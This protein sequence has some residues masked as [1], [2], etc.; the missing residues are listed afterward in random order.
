MNTLTSI[1]LSG[2]M[3]VGLLPAAERPNVIFISIDDMND[4]IGPMNDS[5]ARTP[6]MDRLAKRGITFQNAHTPGV[7][8]APSRAAIFTG[9]YASTTGCYENQVYFRDHPEYRPLQMAFHEAGYATYG[10]GKLYHH[11]AGYYD[12]RGWDEFRV[13]TEEQKK[14]GWPVDTWNYG[15]P[16]LPN[17][18]P[19]SRF[20]T[21]G[22]EAN[23][24]KTE[25]GNDK[26]ESGFMDSGPIPNDKEEL[27]SDTMRANWACEVIKRKHEKP[28][29]M[30]VGFYCPHFPNYAPQK[31]FDLYPLDQMK[32]GPIKAD[33]LDDIPEPTRKEKINRSKI[34]TRLG[35]LGLIPE[36]IQG[37]RASTSYV[38]AMIGRI[39]DAL[40]ASPYRDNT[41]IVLW[42]DNG[43]HF[44]EKGDYGKHTL[45][46]RTSNVPLIWAGPQL[47][48]GA[49]INASAS[50]VDMYPTLIDLCSLKQDQGLE[51]KSLASTLKDPATAVDR[52]VLLPF[53]K[54]GGYTMVNQQWRYI[55]Y[56]NHTEE[57]Y[58][59]TTDP[60]E[61]T[62]LA[63][64]PAYK[65]IIDG[66]K[67]QA[68]TTFATA[69]PNSNELKLVNEGEQFHWEMKEK[70]PEKKK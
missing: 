33:D 22:R 52:T 57:L 13:R 6:N 7:F 32:A 18:Y 53:H 70:K 39:L 64:Q 61:W 30:G 2:L 45:W 50:L 12:Q 67:K 4:W 63:S 46:E 48:K 34:H 37:Y 17:P 20:I 16:P 31:Y 51:G 56:P 9:R 19:H 29:F 8:C 62:N 25:G 5:Q 49:S 14:I 58:N 54:I 59:L 36:V 42:S 3:L 47:A 55:H 60:N 69:G 44:G 43:Y 15:N 41:I 65:E 21:E 1:L 11:P 10:T 68:P 35:E 28:F 66:L 27:M 40:D 38:D 26:K 23:A 24:D